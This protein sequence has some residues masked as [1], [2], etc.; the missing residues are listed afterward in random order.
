MSV[1]LSRLRERDIVHVEATDGRS[2]H[3]VVIRP[4]AQLMVDGQVTDERQH[5]E[6]DPITRNVSQRFVRPSEITAVFRKVGR[7]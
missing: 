1:P 7:K 4:R 2:F 6:V 3:A 5:A